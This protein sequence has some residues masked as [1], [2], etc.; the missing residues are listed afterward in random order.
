MK[1]T[2]LALTLIFALFVASLFVVQV[3]EVAKANAIPW[4]DTPNQDKPV[5]TVKTPQNNSE[6]NAN[7][8]YLNF[9]VTAPDSWNKI[10]WVVHYIGYIHSLDVFLDG[11][12]IRYS[13]SGLGYY[14]NSGSFSV[15]LNQLASGGHMLNVTVLSFT[16]YRGPAYNN[17]HIVSDITSSSGPVYKYPIVVSDIVYFTVVGEPSPSPQETEPEPFPTTLVIAFSV[18]AALVCIGLIV[19]LKK[20]KR[21]V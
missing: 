5:L 9:T 19:Y 4:P 15:K 2:G 18:M 1:R 16:Y 6:Y 3:I 13:H 17:S 21:N 14:N 12:N 10:Y 20:H 11:E 7:G 8:V